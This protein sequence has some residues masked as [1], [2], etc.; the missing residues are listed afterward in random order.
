MNSRAQNALR[1]LIQLERLGERPAIIVLRSSTWNRLPMILEE[2]AEGLAA[3]QKLEHLKPVLEA[4]KPQYE[5]LKSLETI[6]QYI[7]AKHTLAL[8]DVAQGK[9]DT[10]F[11][12]FMLTHT[13]P[14]EE[15]KDASNGCND[16]DQADWSEDLHK[17]WHTDN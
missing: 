17:R 16:S 3:L 12:G 11:I 7:K 8:K 9:L 10:R 1:N 13:C 15:C 2:W 5:F 14:C 4:W 6:E